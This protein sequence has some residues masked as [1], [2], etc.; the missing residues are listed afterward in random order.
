MDPNSSAPSTD[1][2][3]PQQ[4]D[5]STPAEP[6]PPTEPMPAAEPAPA[7]EVI[8]VNEP[9]YP[10]EPMAMPV[11]VEP[12]APAEVPANEPVS[13]M[14]QEPVMPAAEQPSPVQTIVPEA[15]AGQPLGTQPAFG[16]EMPAAISG[17]P[18]PQQPFTPMGGQPPFTPMAA[19]QQPKP[20]GKK[21]LIIIGGAV[22]A[23]IIVAVAVFMLT[24]KAALV[25]SLSS[26][27]FQGLTYKRPASWVKDTS[28]ST[29]VNY[30]PKVSLSKSSSGDPSYALKMNVSAQKNIFGSVPNDLTAPNK[31]ALQKVI[32]QEIS[33]AS[34]DIL[35]AKADVGCTD[36]PV[37]ADKPQKIDVANSF[38]AVKY[39]FTCKSGTGS[40][41]TVFHFSVVDV[42]PNKADI[43]YLVYMGA[44][45]ESIYKTNL[46]QI[47]KILSS[48]SF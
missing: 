47:D 3:Q 25:G 2:A 44:A 5:L 38:L 45:T 7:A 39:S 10:V 40:S 30:H 14:P 13:A 35:P 41:A 8:P 28:S 6:V 31:A 9:T 24:S 17:Q 27:S 26:D 36:D 22:L 1:P 16:S 37:F 11:P 12:V 42:V 33:A 43:E 46:S 20:K 29:A 21:M 15:V 32:D 19:S 4:P 34:K 48:V 23:L 18:L